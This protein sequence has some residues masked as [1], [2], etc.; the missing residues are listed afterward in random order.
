MTNKTLVAKI[1]KP[2]AEALLN[3][4]K[5]NNSLNA[6]TADIND[7]LLILSQL[8]PLKEYFANPVVNIAT[9]KTLIKISL[10]PK[11]NET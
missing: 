9:K 11:L 1:A 3:L 8:K 4:A 7:L 10:S 5:S 6:I 2:Y